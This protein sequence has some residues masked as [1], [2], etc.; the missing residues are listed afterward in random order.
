MYPWNHQESSSVQ[1]RFFYCFIAHYRCHGLQSIAARSAVITW[2]TGSIPQINL[3]Q[4]PVA[5]TIRERA[6]DQIRNSN[7]KCCSPLLTY[8]LSHLLAPNRGHF[9]YWQCIVDAVFLALWPFPRPHC[10][11][12]LFW[13]ELLLPTQF[14]LCQFGS[15][16]ELREWAICL[17]TYSCIKCAASIGDSYP[18]IVLIYYEQVIL[19]IG[20]VLLPSPPMKLH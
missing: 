15:C 14:K 18:G 9:L 10:V 4:E 5:W 17:K 16:S 19:S 6:E 11:L 13:C 8:F 1:W 3:L 7:F 20:T 2:V 12:S